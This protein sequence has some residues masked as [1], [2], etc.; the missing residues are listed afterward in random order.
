MPVSLCQAELRKAEKE[1][2]CKEDDESRNQWWRAYVSSEEYS[3]RIEQ[4]YKNYIDTA[5]ASRT[6]SSTS[7][8]TTWKGNITKLSIYSAVYFLEFL[9]KYKKLE[10]LGQAQ[11]LMEYAKAAFQEDANAKVRLIAV[12]Q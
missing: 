2:R 5:H 4:R 8:V 12:N 7:T 11:K 3:N 10:C 9:R 6:V 1:N